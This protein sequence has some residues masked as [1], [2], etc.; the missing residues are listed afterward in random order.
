[1]TRITKKDLGRLLVRM[2]NQ[3][4]APKGPVWTKREDGKGMRA[5]VGA[6]ILDQ[7]S[8]TYG[9]AWA[10]SEITNEAGGQ[11]SILRARTARELWD[12]TQAWLDGYEHRGQ[13]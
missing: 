12:A 8:A 4:G 11:R 13:A 7:G 6:L 1:M 5:T 10:I 9:N 2:N 3:T